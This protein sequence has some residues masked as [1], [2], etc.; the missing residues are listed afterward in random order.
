LLTVD[1]RSHTLWSPLSD[2][3]VELNEK[4]HEN[5]NVAADDP[6]GWGWLVRVDPANLE[7]ELKGLDRG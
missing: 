7:E 6:G 5:R 3:V 2:S 4:L 1:G